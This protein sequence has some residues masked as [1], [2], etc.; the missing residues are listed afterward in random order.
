MKKR[1]LSLCGIYFLGLATV[2]GLMLAERW[3]QESRS[4]RPKFTEAVF[5]DS[6]VD[7]AASR[8]DVAEFEQSVLAQ[9]SEP[10]FADSDSA[11]LA[12]TEPRGLTNSLAHPPIRSNSM[13]KSG[14]VEFSAPRPARKPQT[15][16]QPP[17]LDFD[18][19][20]AAD[21]KPPLPRNLEDAFD[22]PEETPVINTVPKRSP[23]AVSKERADIPDGIESLAE[24]NPSDEQKAKLTSLREK[25]AELMKAK[26]ELVNEQTLSEEVSALEKQ[27]SDLHAAQ[28]LLSAQQIL[29]AL[30]EEFPESPA[31]V[32]AKRMLK[33]SETNP[34][35][36]PPHGHLR[37]SRVDSPL[38]DLPTYR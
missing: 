15:A 5:A 17:A 13:P 25:L 30:V 11:D 14:P 24:P 18:D 36:L 3:R 9:N 2:P 26:A 1:W 31:A 23:T 29:R 6:A 8:G 4:P 21:V 34:G 10:A 38:S 27:I 33:A 19:S 28:K 35:A 16:P 32:R 20:L 37:S 7:E 12:A 22:L